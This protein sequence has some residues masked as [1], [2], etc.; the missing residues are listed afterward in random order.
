MPASI[1]AV[2]VPQNQSASN[3]APA[4]G[5]SAPAPSGGSMSGSGSSAPNSGRTGNAGSTPQA[6]STPTT[7]SDGGSAPTANNPRPQITA[8]TQGVIGQADYKLSTPG[9]SSQGSVVTSEKGNVKLEGGTMLLLRVS[10]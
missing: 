7:T 2:I 1:Q 5:S 8:S 3:A 6:S 10:Q 4:G 9:D